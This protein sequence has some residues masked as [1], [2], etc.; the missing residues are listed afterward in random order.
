MLTS[1]VLIDTFIHLFFCVS[2]WRSHL[3]NK[4][5]RV[6]FFLCLL[7]TW[8]KER[9]I[10]TIVRWED[11]KKE[12]AIMSSKSWLMNLMKQRNLS[13]KTWRQQYK[14]RWLEAHCCCRWRFTDKF[15]KMTMM[16]SSSSLSKPTYLCAWVLLQ[17][18]I[19]CQRRCN[20][21]DCSDVQR[22]SWNPSHCSFLSINDSMNKCSQ[23]T[24]TFFKLGYKAMTYPIQSL[25]VSIG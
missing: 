10:I 21:C 13:V 3:K 16:M 5:D 11:C 22:T 6:Q 18:C 7:R 2:L 14:K 20:K 25:D 24:N 19:T 12:T 4:E 9:I 23:H 8:K 1:F 15:L 17:D